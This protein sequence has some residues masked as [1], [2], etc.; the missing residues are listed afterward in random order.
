MSPSPKKAICLVSG[1]MDSLVCAAKAAQVND[2]LYFLHL[3]Y[4]Q[5]TEDKEL[6]AFHNIA[7]HYGVCEERRKVID[8]GFL[9]SIGG[10][11]LTDD[12][13]PVTHY[14]GDSENI[15]TSYV[16]F[17]NSIILSLSVAWAEV[18]GAS[19]IYIGA[20]EEDS[21]GYPDC[22]ESYFDAYNKMIEE[23]TAASGIHIVTPIIHL[24]K[25]EIV[26]EALSLKAPLHLSW[27]C[28][29]SEDQA[30]GVCDSCA[31]R[32]RGFSRAGVVDPIDY[33]TRPQYTEES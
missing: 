10:S 14:E 12:S 21:S 26:K 32:L 30:C 25:E 24:K 2:E 31:L 33:K 28:Y 13:M 15:P 6:Q 20:V 27:S 23:G 29:S 11:S 22:R 5:N 16:P 19:K 9:K 7:F 4:G 3:N 18:V 17:R 8:L 1:G